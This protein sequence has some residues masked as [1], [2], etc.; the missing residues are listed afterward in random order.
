VSSTDHVYIN[1]FLSKK[2]VYSLRFGSCEC[3]AFNK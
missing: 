2:V 1:G 3:S